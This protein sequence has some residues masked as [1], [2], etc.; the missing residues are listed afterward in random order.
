MLVCCR[1][2]GLVLKIHNTPYYEGWAGLALMA[3]SGEPGLPMLQHL[4]QQQQPLA[5]YFE[6]S[7]AGEDVLVAS[8]TLYLN[9][10]AAH[11]IRCVTGQSMTPHTSA[12]R[13]DGHGQHGHLDQWRPHRHD[14]R[15][16]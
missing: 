1:E 3:G 2:L 7:G 14:S 15:C 6:R 8:D 11:L 13:C 12:H 4:A 10:H 9:G 5:V 16:L